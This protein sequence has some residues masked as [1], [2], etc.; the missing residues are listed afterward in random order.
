MADAVKADDSVKADLMYA[1]TTCSTPSTFSSSSSTY[2]DSD[3]PAWQES[4]ES[5]VE[6]QP[7]GHVRLAARF[8]DMEQIELLASAPSSSLP[9]SLS[10][11]GLECGS[12]DAAPIAW[13]RRARWQF[14]QEEFM[15]P[16]PESVLEVE[17]AAES[18]STIEHVI[19]VPFRQKLQKCD[20]GIEESC[21]TGPVVAN[22]KICRSS[23]VRAPRALEVSSSKFSSPTVASGQFMENKW[24]ARMEAAKEC[25]V[26][27]NTQDA[28]DCSADHI[29]RAE[30]Q[31]TPVQQTWKCIAKRAP[32]LEFVDVDQTLAVNHKTEDHRPNTAATSFKH[33]LSVSYMVDDLMLF[34]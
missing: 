20:Y 27:A 16:L 29:V 17:K 23:C 33:A 32:S 4:E 22:S 24:A 30:P 25:P 7:F 1:A 18:Q 21:Y 13:K 3:S 14:E 6:P 15:G 5:F 8:N 12:Q 28:T 19:A 34:P 31:S 9:E 10:A 26:L 11:R 2:S